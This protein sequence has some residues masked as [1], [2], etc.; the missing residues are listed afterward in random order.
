MEGTVAADGARRSAPLT[1]SR[2]TSGS[3]LTKGNATRQPGKN[4][5]QT[6]DMVSEEDTNVKRRLRSTSASAGQVWRKHAEI[7]D[8][9]DKVVPVL[10]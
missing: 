6:E 10:H 5:L 3:I 2:V 8:V 7:R 1:I 4:K 9:L